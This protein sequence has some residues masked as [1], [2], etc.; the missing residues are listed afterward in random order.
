[1]LELGPLAEE[2]VAVWTVQLP[3]DYASA[4]LEVEEMVDEVEEMLVLS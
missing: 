4:A 2:L 3:F 1:M